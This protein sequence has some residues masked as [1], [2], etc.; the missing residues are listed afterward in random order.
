MTN[1]RPRK[2]TIPLANEPLGHVDGKPVFP[3]TAW[4]EFFDGVWSRTGKYNDEG[5]DDSASISS[6][7]ARIES[8]A[9]ALEAL[10]ASLG[11]DD[12]SLA[13]LEDLRRR[14]NELQATQTA[15][16]S[17]VDAQIAEVRDQLNTFGALGVDEGF[18]PIGGTGNLADLNTVG[19]PEIDTDAVTT[20][21]NDSTATDVTL[22]VS[23]NVSIHTDSIELEEDSKAVIL[24]QFSQNEIYGTNANIQISN[25]AI[26]FDRY[27]FLELVRDP[28]GTPVVLVTQ[29]V[30]TP[31][32]A[33]T[34]LTLTAVPNV[35]F[36][37]ND[38]SHGG[39]TVE[40][41]L[42]LVSYSDS[43]KVTTAGSNIGMTNVRRN[44][45]ILQAKR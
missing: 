2:V 9:D 16:L 34:N 29:N 10:I 33:S 17:N 22:A 41:G 18:V 11:A 8:V 5:F 37:Y 23:T 32:P 43:G 20:V 24:V 1:V 27:V 19:T 39:G 12:G 15:S 30:A 13:E 14:I 6:I 36:T 21:E 3:S 44:M 40:Y 7:E 35:G 45:L 28:S 38:T 4:G 26:G 42:R 31:I 25:A